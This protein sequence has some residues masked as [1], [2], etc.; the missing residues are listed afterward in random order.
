MNP[1][2][3]IAIGAAIGFLGM[4]YGRKGLSSKTVNSARD[5]GEGALRQ[6]YASAEKTLRSAAVS[7]LSTVEKASSSLRQRL[8][9]D[10]PEAE[11]APSSEPEPVKKPRR[12]AAAPKSDP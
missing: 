7:G 5:A 9:P 12:R 10:E 8:D 4:R 3:A 1:L 6:G 11:D 2:F